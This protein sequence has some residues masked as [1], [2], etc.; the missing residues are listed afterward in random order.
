MRIGNAI[1]VWARE[2]LVSS[3]G[4]IISAELLDFLKE[5]YKTIRGK[6]FEVD[7]SLLESVFQCGV[8]QPGR[9]VTTD[10]FDK[11]VLYNALSSFQNYAFGL[12]YNIPQILQSGN[13]GKPLVV[14]A[15]ANAVSDLNAWYNPQGKDL[16]FGTYGDMAK[17]QDRWHL[18]SDSDVSTHEFGHLLLD[19]INPM[20][21][22]SWT[23]EGRAIHEGFSDALAAL[24]FNDPEMSED[25]AVAMG[26]QPSPTD[27]LRN[28]DNNDVI[29][30]KHTEE[31][32]R[33]KV[34]GGF[35]WSIKK[36]LTDPNGPFKLPERVA[37]DLTLRILLEHGSHYQTSKPK[38][39][40]FVQAVYLAIESLKRSDTLPVD[41]AQLQ[42]VV[43][44]EAAR[45]KLIKQPADIFNRDGIFY[46]MKEAGRYAG[47]GSRFELIQGQENLDGRQ[48]IYQQ[49]YMTS[50]G[51]PLD[52]IGGALFLQKDQLG[53]DMFV[54]VKDVRPLNKGDIDETIKISASEAIDAIFPDVHDRFYRSRAEMMAI[55]SGKYGRT[56]TI[57]DFAD[58][59]FEN[60]VAEEA[61][62][63]LSVKSFASSNENVRLVIIPNSNDLHYEVKVGMGTYYVNAKTKSVVFMTE[64]I[65]FK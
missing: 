41:A 14:R 13:K 45:R 59:Q 19:H 56:K 60:R 30:D 11:G 61:M 65:R 64:A 29:D 40:D 48:E 27:G 38:T 43:Q 18:A 20:L 44:M 28:V 36:A 47:T 24:Y 15:H 6:Y 37:S 32:D 33:G 17:G 10:C 54:S 34:Y 53:L 16:T 9:K 5:D 52:V 49:Q 25:F 62:K 4:E 35:F 7:G 55:S 2:N 39:E 42:M 21:V 31:H 23:G 26:R 50:R 57:D 1:S 46:T 51:E 8:F 22:K 58:A 63:R 12:G 3:N